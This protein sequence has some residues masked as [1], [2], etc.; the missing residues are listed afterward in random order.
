MRHV[1]DLLRGPEAVDSAN[2][3]DCASL[4]YLSTIN[5]QERNNKEKPFEGHPPEYVQPGTKV[6]CFPFPRK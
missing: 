1:R 2:A 4:T 6:C 3:I 5:L